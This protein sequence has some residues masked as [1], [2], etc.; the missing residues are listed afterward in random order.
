MIAIDPVCHGIQGYHPSDRFRT[1]R[2]NV[3]LTFAVLTGSAGGGVGV[4]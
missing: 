3:G 4:A 1:Q 2:R